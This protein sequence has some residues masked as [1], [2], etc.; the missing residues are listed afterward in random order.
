MQPEPKDSQRASYLIPSMTGQHRV[1][2]PSCSSSSLSPAYQVTQCE[3][4]V[5][6]EASGLQQSSAD[7]FKNVSECL[8][9]RSLLQIQT[10]EFRAVKSAEAAETLGQQCEEPSSPHR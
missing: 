6:D 5:M 8:S 1:P 3:G 10:E 9:T 4:E 7:L 2:A